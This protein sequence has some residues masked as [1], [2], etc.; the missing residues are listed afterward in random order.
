[1][2]EYKLTVQDN[3]TEYLLAIP[4]PNSLA[5]TIAHPLVK[6]FICI[7]GSPKSVLIDQGKSSLSNLI[8]RPAQRLRTR[9]LKITAFHPQ[10]NGS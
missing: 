1:M 6:K 5:I 4:L 2:N 3:F 7:F 9:Q 10:S 8:R